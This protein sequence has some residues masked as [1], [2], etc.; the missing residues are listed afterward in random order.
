MSTP[1]KIG[2]CAALLVVVG[3]GVVMVRTPAH[4]PA[5][6]VSLVSYA[7]NGR[8]VVLKFTNNTGVGV[9]CFGVRR[10]VGWLT[11]GL[12]LP[13]HEAGELR[14][15]LREQTPQGLYVHCEEVH[16][17]PYHLL[18]LAVNGGERSTGFVVSVTL[19]PRETNAPAQPVTP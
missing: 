12:Y 8:T 14:A 1:T 3:A 18:D 2:L 4:K 5:V 16:G 13:A 10:G 11:Q 19:P 15:N 6:T 9:R 7:D 17:W